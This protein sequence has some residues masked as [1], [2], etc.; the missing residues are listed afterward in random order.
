MNQQLSVGDRT[1]LDDGQ[2]ILRARAIF[3]SC[4]AC[5]YEVGLAGAARCPECGTAIDDTHREVARR[6]ALLTAGI[7]GE[8]LRHLGAWGAVVGAYAIGAGVVGGAPGMVISAAMA[9]SLAVGLSGV[10]GLIVARFAG[11]AE[12]DVLAIGWA[13]SLWWMHGPWLVIGPCAIVVALT[14]G[15]DRLFNSGAAMT[16]MAC[17]LGVAAWALACFY[18]LVQSF[19]TLIDVSERHSLGS[20]RGHTRTVVLVVLGHL[21]VLTFAGTVVLGFAG[22]ALAGQRAFEFAEPAWGF[23]D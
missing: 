1:V 7:R 21:I 8:C 15:V 14:A 3:G 19:M 22:G 18:F 20:G 5:G 17:L 12:R 23:D 13:R 2:E 4:V 10:A 9:M 16:V 6:R 11:R